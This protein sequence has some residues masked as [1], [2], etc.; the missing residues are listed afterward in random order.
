MNAEIHADDVVGSTN[1]ANN[2]ISTVCETLLN[3]EITETEIKEAIQSLKNNK[4]S[5]IDGIA[6]ENLL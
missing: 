1:I 2:N 4:A 3:S 6:N 5:G